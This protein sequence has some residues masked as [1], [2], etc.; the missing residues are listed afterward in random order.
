VSRAKRLFK[1]GFLCGVRWAMSFVCD[2]AAKECR[3]REMC[4]GRKFLEQTEAWLAREYAG[5]EPKQK[6]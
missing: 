4:E 6:S 2:L 5:E 3:R 1:K